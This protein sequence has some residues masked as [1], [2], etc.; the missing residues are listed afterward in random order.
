MKTWLILLALA[1]LAG[2]LLIA[3]RPDAP[4][5]PNAPAA[6][7]NAATSRGPSFEVRVFPPRGGLPLFGILPDWF[8]TRLDG[9]PHELG[10]GPASPGAAIGRVAPDR[11]EL[12]ADGWDLSL[13]TDRQGRIAPGTRLV[14]PLGLGGRQMTLRCRPKGPGTGYLR[15]TPRPGTGELG[16]T[17]L[18]KLATCEN[19][20]S[21]KTANWP[22]APLTVQ[23]S[24][25]G[26]ALGRR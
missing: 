3:S 17:F 23:G 6:A 9:T 2:L 25:A 19:A 5:A 14:F 21:G 24:F 15:T 10:F 7:G 4:A 20:V 26:L 18:V 8:V 12:R 1:L 16:G 22:P 11:L 13:Q